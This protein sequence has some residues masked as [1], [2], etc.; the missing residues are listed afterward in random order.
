[1][2]HLNEEQFVLHH[3]HDDESPLPIEQ[4]LAGCEICRGEY[5]KL[6]GV[7]AL[8]DELPVPDRGDGYG[9]QVWNRLRWRLERRRRKTWMSALAAAAVLAMVFF[10]GQLWNARR[11]APPP[12]AASAGE[13][14]GAP[15]KA[16][17]ADTRDRVLVFVVGDHLDNSERMLL[18]VANADAKHELDLSGENKRAADLVASN[19]IYRQTAVQR[20]DERIASLLT[21][22]EPILVE[23]S[24]AEKLTP[25]E[26]RSL[27]KRIDS[28]GL[29]FK[30]RVLSAETNGGDAPHPSTKGTNSL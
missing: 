3:Y 24:H 22:L 10:A 29:L 13:S 28:R 9:E 21:D 2:E 15:Q 14:V 17:N 8:V 5:A 4:H 11:G 27:Q 20:G 16:K 12:P 26:L 30:V 23:L 6:R 7:L 18:E 19:R 25:E 1:M